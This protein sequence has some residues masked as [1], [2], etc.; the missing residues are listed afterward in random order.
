MDLLAIATILCFILN[1]IV[2]RRE[3][4]HWANVGHC[5]CSIMSDTLLVL[6]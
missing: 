3:L 6:S 4:C 5:R 2:R 1:S